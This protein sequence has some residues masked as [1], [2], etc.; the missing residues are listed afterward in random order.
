MWTWRDRVEVYALEDGRYPAP[1]IKYAPETLN[2]AGLPG[3]SVPVVEALG[4]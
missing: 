4:G 1:A 2:P 3:L